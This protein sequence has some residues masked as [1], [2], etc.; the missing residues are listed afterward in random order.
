MLEVEVLLTENELAEQFLAALRA[1]Y[2]PEKFF[3]WFPLSVRAW[4]NL[5]QSAAPYKNFSRSY[6]LISKYAAEIAR[7]AA[8]ASLEKLE[9]VGL[10]AGQ[11]DKDL[12]VL[13]ALRAEG[14]ATSYRP[15]DSSQALLEVALESAAR[16]QFAARGLKADLADPRTAQALA[17]SARES[18]L[19]LVVGN[20]LGA[21]GPAKFLETLRTVLRPEDRILLDGEIFDDEATM[22]GYDNP[23]NRRFAFAPLASVG[24]EQGRDGELI[25][26]SR[27]D[28]SLDGV[29]LVS[30]YFRASHPLEI[31]LA[32]ERVPLSAAEK[33]EMSS[34]YKY[35]GAA[36]LRLVRESGAL[37]PLAEY[38]SDDAR[39]VMLLARPAAVSQSDMNDC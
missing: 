2:L 28:A 10:G 19:Y 13:D 5:C 15:V 11:G 4:L 20:T 29:Y 30:K 6:G 24:L 17:A 33:I 21:T 27:R 26:E 9:V 38:L 25:F 31:R 37:E 3:Y 16:N 18:R 39:F 36:F 7:H 1:R 23:V 32:A 34:S 22:A 35:T 8:R 14:V 12:L